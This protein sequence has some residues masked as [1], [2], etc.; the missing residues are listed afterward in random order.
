VESINEK[1]LLRNNK[2]GVRNDHVTFFQKDSEEYTLLDSIFA[3]CNANE[4][5]KIEK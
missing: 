4:K 5:I 1:S 3:K 2:A